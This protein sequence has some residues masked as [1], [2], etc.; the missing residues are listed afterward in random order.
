M[1]RY[2]AML[3][4]QEAAPLARQVDVWT[5]E[6]QQTSD[7]WRIV[8][9]APGLRVLSLV[10]RGT[11]PVV[12]RMTGAEG[13]VIGVLFERGSERSGRV[14]ELDTDATQRVIASEG[15][16]LTK[17]HWGNYVAIWRDAAS[18][19]VTVIRDPCGAVP[20]LM[21]TQQGVD[22]FFAHAEDVATLS[23]TSFTID[24]TYIHAFLIFNY[25]I[26]HH[27]G[28]ENIGELLPGRRLTWRSGARPI[29]QWAWSAAEL[30]SHRRY[31]SF[32]DAIA[33]MREAAEAAFTA[34]GRE[35]RRVIVSLSGGLDSSILLGLLRR[36]SDADILALHYV[37]SDYE[38]HERQFARLAAKASNVE[39]VEASQSAAK[40][41]LPWTFNL[42]RLARPKRALLA[43]TIDR[44]S[45]DAAIRFR[46]DTQMLGQGGDHL[47]LQRD[48]ARHTASDYLRSHGFSGSY[49]GE[50]YRSAKLQQR[51]I[52]P[53][54]STSVASAFEKEN[55]T[56]FHFLESAIWR[57][58]SPFTNADL[59]AVPK[60]YI[61]HPWI[62]DASA[63]PIG[64]ALQVQ[65]L[66][67]LHDYYVHHGRGLQ[68][69]I[70][71]PLFAQPVVE[72]SLTTP[73]YLLCNGGDDRAL[74]RA[75]FADV[76][77]K[78]IQNRISK[79]G[80]NRAT[81]DTMIKRLGC[82][83]ELILGGE[84]MNQLAID[85]SWVA[86][87][88]TPKSIAR[89]ERNALIRSLAAVELWNRPWSA[90]SARDA[91]RSPRDISV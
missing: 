11:E 7:R 24:W 15:D 46:A 1:D 17:H 91:A 78:P 22:L 66:V 18:R 59:A 31:R 47:F 58:G 53:V 36:N 38:G 64:K 2:V 84:V 73:T 62:A 12:T 71:H 69:D 75:A 34:W 43:T 8:L 54:L 77:P 26:T 76:L 35:Y 70:V 33:G 61:H 29:L 50:A 27:T 87:A 68:L 79:G 63:L 16:R 39:L 28:I 85:R 45:S 32:P 67:W 55:R 23:D 37:G 56:P 72:A 49:L 90:S 10:H 41:E 51:A 48:L 14:R 6:L 80:A 82:F 5:G 3:W 20:C 65:G 9:D 89:G 86:E 52:W 13:V 21:T 88:L 30:A 25:F 42:P 44:I 19:S 74:A 4:D 40:E 81:S 83:Q 60:A 57:R